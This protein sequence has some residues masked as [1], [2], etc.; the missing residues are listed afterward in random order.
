MSV[1]AEATVFLSKDRK[2]AVR[3][4]HMETSE[5]WPNPPEWVFPAMDFIVKVGDVNKQYTESA[6]AVWASA[7]QNLT[8]DDSIQVCPCVV[9]KGPNEYSRG[10]PCINALGL[11]K[12]YHYM[13][14][15][16]P[17]R[18]V[19]EYEKEVMET[20]RIMFTAGDI[21]SRIEMHDDGEIAE[22]LGQPAVGSKRAYSYLVGDVKMTE[23]DMVATMKRN[24][25]LEK[26]NEA[27]KAQVESKAKQYA[28]LVTRMSEKEPEKMGFRLKDLVEEM[29][30]KVP[31]VLMDV[32]EFRVKAAFEEE[33]DG[34]T[35]IRNR[36]TAYYYPD[37][38]TVEALVRTQFVLI[39]TECALKAPVISGV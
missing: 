5:N 22:Q 7:L 30:L 13:I 36:K 1:H 28:N 31:P 4:F 17:H 21:Q 20:L 38:S 16:F 10:V 26:E 18:V 39:Q 33:F 9:M 12:L 6:G 14:Q 25:E 37:K 32:L 2:V 29:K 24:Q 3:V 34:K 19:G 35:F 8:D 15:R 27:L 11:S 23:A